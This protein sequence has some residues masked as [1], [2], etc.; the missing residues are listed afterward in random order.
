MA[1]G[2]LREYLPERLKKNITVVSAGT[3]GLINSPA[4]IEAV[5]ALAEIGIDISKH[6][7]RG[8]TQQLME[9]SQIILTMAENHYDLLC[10]H[11]PQLKENIFLLRT[12]DEELPVYNKSIA[13]PIG[14]GL[15]VYR[16]SRDIISGEIKRILPRILQLV[17][18]Y[19]H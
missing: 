14:Q 4:S 18:S 8:I 3:M 9:N 6:R 12:F 15:N 11:F 10:E 17:D 2:I 16:Q 13:D 19:L 5:T 7:S 1:E